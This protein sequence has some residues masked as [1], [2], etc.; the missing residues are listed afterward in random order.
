MRLIET[1]G[2]RLEAE[3][4]FFQSQ[5]LREDIARLSQMR[6]L[7][8]SAADAAAYTNA[9]LLLGWTAGNLRTHEIREPLET[10]AE[11]VYC[12]ETGT[13]DAGQ[14]A[15]IERAWMNLHRARMERLMGC[16]STPAPKPAG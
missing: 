2:R 1:L 16:L 4:S 12:F 3:Q 15:L 13:R 9:T 11:A 14:E 10:L 6:E 8:H 7:V 5:L